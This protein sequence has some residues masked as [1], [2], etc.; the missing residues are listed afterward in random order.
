MQL[1]RKDAAASSKYNF[2]REAAVTWLARLKLEREQVLLTQ[3]EAVK[4]QEEVHR[5]R[6]ERERERAQLEL[7]MRIAMVEKESGLR[8]N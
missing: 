3:I 4:A 8:R 7:Q 1:I 2:T 5:L 6:V